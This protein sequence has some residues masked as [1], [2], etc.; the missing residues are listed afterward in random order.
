MT[1]GKTIMSEHPLIDS[2]L[3]KKKEIDDD[4]NKIKI[5][6]DEIEIINDPK[7]KSFIRSVMKM[8]EPFWV[9]PASTV[10]ETHPPDEYG[11]E[12]LIIH[13]KRV[14][15]IAA[16][17]TV[18]IDLTQEEID[19]ILAA[20]LLHDIT[21][22]YWA[23]ESNTS[24]IHDPMHIYT[25]DGM[26]KMCRSYDEENNIHPPQDNTL[27]IEFNHLELILKLIRYS[28]GI[29]SPIPET[30]PKNELEN[31]VHIADFLASSLHIIVD[32]PEI[33]KD[34]WI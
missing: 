27:D 10:P 34:R 16:L 18:T 28:H 30:I 23:D 4:D 1:V 29:F 33:N 19:C 21:K 24:V 17:L 12:G 3:E 8:A 22:A 9:S 32:G 13:T 2:L 26:V 6:H 31:I 5:F 14:V 25:V 20:A 15:R 11:P 7:I